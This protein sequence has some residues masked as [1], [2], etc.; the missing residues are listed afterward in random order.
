MTAEGV[1]AARWLLHHAKTRGKSDLMLA[2]AQVHA[3]LAV[4]AEVAETNRL[5]RLVVKVYDDAG[6]DLTLTT[7]NVEVRNT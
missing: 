2:A 1:V 6:N 3:T 7:S 5:I 4:A